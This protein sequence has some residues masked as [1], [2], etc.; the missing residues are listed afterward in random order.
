MANE[1]ELFY[2]ILIVILTVIMHIVL[3]KK[4]PRHNDKS[5]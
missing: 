3:F 1:T 5:S 4:G 2:L